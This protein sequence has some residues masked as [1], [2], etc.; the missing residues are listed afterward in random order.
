MPAQVSPATVAGCSQRISWN[1]ITA[2]SMMLKDAPRYIAT[3]FRPKRRMPFRS[4]VRVNS[5][6]AAGK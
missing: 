2:P 3:S 6:N 5:T 1:A 4:T